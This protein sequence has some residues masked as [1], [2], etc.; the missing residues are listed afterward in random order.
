MKPSTVSTPDP[1][2]VQSQI[3]IIPG[4]RMSGIYITMYF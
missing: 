3:K 1:Y 2:G 4:S